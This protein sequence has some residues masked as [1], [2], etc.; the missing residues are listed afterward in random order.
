MFFGYQGIAKILTIIGIEKQAP[1]E[2]VIAKRRIAKTHQQL[3]TRF[4]N[5]TLAK[6]KEYIEYDHF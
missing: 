4:T 5:T 2:F 1:V 3:V 6:Y